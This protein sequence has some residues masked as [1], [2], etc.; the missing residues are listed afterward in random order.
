[1]VSVQFL[2]HIFVVLYACFHCSVCCESTALVYKVQTL[3]MPLYY[4][5]FDTQCPWVTVQ[6][7]TLYHDISILT[8][9][10]QC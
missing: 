2:H 5:L 6:L 8:V 1:M 7:A 10:E 4:L 3:D 9:S